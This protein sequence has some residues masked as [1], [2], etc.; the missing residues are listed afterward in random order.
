MWLNSRLLPSSRYRALLRHCAALRA[1]LPDA[2]H[3]LLPHLNVFM[4]I[5]GGYFGQDEELAVLWEEACF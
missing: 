4:V 1:S 2:R 3:P 5:A